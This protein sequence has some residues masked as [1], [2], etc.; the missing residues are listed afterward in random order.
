MKEDKADPFFRIADVDKTFPGVK[1]LTNVSFDLYPGEIHGLIGEN[2][3]GKSTLVHIISGVLQPDSGA[4][5]IDREKVVFKSEKES[6]DSGIAAVYQERSLFPSLSVANNIF[7]NRQP[8]HPLGFISE[9]KLKEKAAEVLRKLNFPI[10]PGALVDDLSIA[11]QKLVE[12]AKAL[13]LNAKILILDEPSEAI[14]ESEVDVLFTLLR[15]LK[16]K[17]IGI[18][19]I[20]HRL[21]EIVK[22]ADRVTVLKDGKHVGTVEVGTTNVSQLIKMMTGR[23]IGFEIAQKTKR[24]ISESRA[25]EIEGFCCGRS[26]RN[27]SLDVKEGETLGIT[28][29]KG[30]GKSE[31]AK[32]LFGILRRD[33]GDVSIFGNRVK[34]ES[35]ADALKYGMGYLSDQRKEEGVF[36]SMDIEQNIL[37]GN[38]HSFSR[39][40]F[41][42][43]TRLYEE[44]EKYIRKLN[45][46]TPSAKQKLKNLSGGNQQKTV[47]A[48]LLNQSL[49]IMVANEPTQGIDIGAKQEIYAILRDLAESGTTIVIIS[50]EFKE[51]IAFCDRIIVLYEGNVVGQL[52]RED[53][54]EEEIL[55]LASGIIKAEE[56]VDGHA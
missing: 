16:K 51:L 46:V 32:C 44:A 34:I 17:G 29:L 43:E 5:Y 14:A 28:G 21:G 6:L 41:L 53:A 2:G 37:A 7:P 10:D 27:V 54:T 33:S 26:L 39:L 35:P 45:I 18:I 4:I 31:L 42:E 9:F 30:S 25:L 24:S 22:I 1:A 48:K 52:D 19:Y 11:E 38:L 23:E 15:E 12:I 40:G 8:L 50:S 56:S 49:R 55:N 3:A 13:S 20:T 36:A 47:I